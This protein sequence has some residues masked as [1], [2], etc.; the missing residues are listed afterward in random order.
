[1]AAP[2]TKA[3]VSLAHVPEAWSLPGATRCQ[4]GGKPGSPWPWGREGS[5]LAW[6]PWGKER[7]WPLPPP[8]GS[9]SVPLT[10]SEG[11]YL[12]LLCQF[13]A[14]AGSLPL[15]RPPWNNLRSAT[16]GCG[17]G[18]QLLAGPWREATA[19]QP[20]PTP[21]PPDHTG[22]P[23]LSEPS[24]RPQPGVEHLMMS[25]TPCPSEGP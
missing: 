8:R 21:R 4:C 18:I 19:D 24:G 2:L 12:G 10:W 1:M 7:R 14:M 20:G 22:A 3:P 11:G 16:D 6:V 15:V 17:C 9:P 23:L 13:P 25:L 5:S